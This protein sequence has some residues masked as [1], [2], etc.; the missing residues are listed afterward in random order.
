MDG[1][2]ARLDAEGP[3]PEVSSILTGGSAWEP[4]PWA[5]GAA[6]GVGSSRIRRGRYGKVVLPDGM[7]E[8]NRFHELPRR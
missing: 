2:G 3:V 7:E 5:G 4:T 8:M 1:A 6:G